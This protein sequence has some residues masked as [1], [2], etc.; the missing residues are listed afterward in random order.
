MLIL[1]RFTP[2]RKAVLDALRAALAAQTDAQGNR[3]YITVMF[4]F[5]KPDSQDYLQ[6]VT[7]IAHLARFV[8]ADFTDSKIVNAEVSAIAAEVTLPILP[9]LQAGS[10]PE[11]LPGGWAA[12][13]RGVLETHRYQDQESLIAGLAD[14]VIGPVEANRAELKRLL[15]NLP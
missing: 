14:Q 13:Y 6:P 5:A 10:P 4:D 15:H 2:E 8:I 1:G 12:Q 7:T 9:L 11:Y 3:R